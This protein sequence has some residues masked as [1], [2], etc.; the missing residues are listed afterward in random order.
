MIAL[1]GSKAAGLWSWKHVIN[2][3]LAGLV[4]GSRSYESTAQ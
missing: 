3:V 4:V 1:L 2:N